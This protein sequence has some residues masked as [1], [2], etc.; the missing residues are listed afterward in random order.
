MIES[1]YYQNYRGLPLKVATMDGDSIYDS[2]R[3]KYGKNNNWNGVL[4][5]YEELF[6]KNSGNK[7]F[8]FEFENKEGTKQWF[9]GFVNDIKQYFNPPIMTNMSQ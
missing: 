4:W 9:N 6:G 2:I 8:Y 3:E 7:Q 1:V 5:T